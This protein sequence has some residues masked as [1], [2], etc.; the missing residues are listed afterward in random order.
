MTNLDYK[1][2]WK[3]NKDIQKN[4]NLTEF[5]NTYVSDFKNTRNIDF[6]LIWKWSVENPEIFWDAIW[7]YTKIIGEKGN[8]ILK[9]KDKMPGAKFFPDS[10]V[11]YAE[12][13]LRNNDERLAIISSREDGVNCKITISEYPPNK[14]PP[15]RLSKRFCHLRAI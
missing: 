6:Q 10:K 3:P 4:S 9:D 14:L 8:I 7:G 1:T 5:V 12:N 11:N 15:L 2:L 13:I